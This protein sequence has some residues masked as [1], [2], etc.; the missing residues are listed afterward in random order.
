MEQKLPWAWTTGR[1]GI[2]LWILD[3]RCGDCEST[4]GCDSPVNSVSWSP[5]G[6]KIA[7]GLDDGVR[8]F[9]SASSALIR[10][11]LDVE[12]VV[13]SSVLFSMD[14]CKIA[15]CFQRLRMMMTNFRKVA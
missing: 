2:R 10:S 15:T 5:D 9:D 12:A 4:L 1:S 7:A 14:G 8:I 13:S 3:S 11:P 6:S